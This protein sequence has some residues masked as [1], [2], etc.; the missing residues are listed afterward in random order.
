VI[1]GFFLF[2]DIPDALTMSGAL[3]VVGSTLYITWREARLQRP[4]SA[5][6]AR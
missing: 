6:A 5:D 1:L 3:I 2:G 4:A